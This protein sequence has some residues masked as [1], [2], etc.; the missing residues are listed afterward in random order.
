MRF[1]LLMVSALAM[2]AGCSGPQ[3][4]NEQLK[5]WM[6]PNG[7]V[8]VLSTIAMIDDL[9]KQVG[10]EHVDTLVLIAGQLDPHSY[11]LVKGDDEKFFVAD[12]IFF[13]GLNLEHGPS[14]QKTL[15]SNAKALGLGNKLQEDDA[16]RI[17]HY[18]GQLDPHIWMDTAL[19]SKTIPYIVKAL[20]EKDPANAPYYRQNG[21]RLQK[22][23][24]EVD[25][26][27]K[28]DL[29]A[30]P[31]KK[32]YLVSSH[33]AFNYFAKAYLATTEEVADGTWQKR[34][35]APEGLAPD[36][37]LS[38]TDIRE[39]IDHLTKY[40][41][42]VLFPESNLSRDSIRKIVDAGKES[43]LNLWIADCPLFADAMG[44]PGHEGDTYVKMVQYNA[45]LIGLYLRDYNPHNEKS[46]CPDLYHSEEGKNES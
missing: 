32:R 43:G 23:L 3:Q 26:K 19:W 2:L 29:Q 4:R 20:S 15:Y 38:A 44:A 39:I 10:G 27:I 18:N 28:V 31:E 25:H 21:E 22:E 5:Q 33:D 35:T 41:I 13:N 40:N 8:K 6:A 24:E 46:M 45:K 30:I 12:I 42:Q 14:L 7:K 34:F 17:L 16:G 37:Q 1:L 11:Q 9:V 36:S